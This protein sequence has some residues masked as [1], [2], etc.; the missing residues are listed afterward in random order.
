MFKISENDERE[1][2]KDV[3]YEDIFKIRKL[4]LSK[5]NIKDGASSSNHSV[6]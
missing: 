5:Y 1:V 4:D 3:K 6:I 2:A